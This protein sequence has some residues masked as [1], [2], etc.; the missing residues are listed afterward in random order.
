VLAK[1][2][3]TQA[4]L[5]A[6][7]RATLLDDIP[8]VPICSHDYEDGRRDIPLVAFTANRDAT[9]EAMSAR[10]TQALSTGRP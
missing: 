10:L 9:I 6:Y 4:A 5:Q 7:T 8:H 3:V 2:A 1:N